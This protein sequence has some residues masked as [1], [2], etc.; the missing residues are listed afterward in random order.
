M[1]KIVNVILFPN[2]LFLDKLKIVL[3]KITLFTITGPCELGSVFFT[4]ENSCQNNG[5]TKQITTYPFCECKCNG[6]YKGDYCRE[7]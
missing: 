1:S 4:N 7:R 6:D 3:I 2:A 5:I